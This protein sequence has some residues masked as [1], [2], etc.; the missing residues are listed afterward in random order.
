LQGA[1]LAGAMFFWSMGVSGDVEVRWG[2]S[3]ENDL[4][5]G[6]DR[7]D[8]PGIIRNTSALGGD[9]KVS[10]VPDR[11]RFV[12]DLK[13]VW[14]GFS[15]D[16]TFEGL[17]NYTVSSPLYLESNAAYVELRSLLP[18]LDVRFG[19]QIINWGAADMFN[20]TNNLNALNLEDP[21]MFGKRI[22]NQMIRIDYS[23]DDN[24]V[25]TAAW[26]PAFQPALLPPSSLLAIGDP[27]SEFPFVDP[28]VR[29]EAE[30]L[31]DFWL[32]SPDDWLISQPDVQAQMPGFALKNS[33]VGVRLGWTMGLFDASLS[34]YLG[35]DTM[36]VPVSSHS[37]IDT[38]NVSE[39][40]SPSGLP[41]RTI[42]TQVKLVYPRK[43]VL[44][45]DIT[46]QVPFLDDMGIWFE[47]A[48]VFPEAVRMNFDIT[49]IVP[50]AKILKGETLTSRPYFKCTTGV[51]YSI[52]QHF[53][54]LAQ[55]MRGFVDE[56]GA[57]RQNNYWMAGLDSKWIQEKLLLRLFVL[58]ELPHEDDDL[59]L[60]DERKD[61]TYV[62]SRAMGAT[63]D[64]TIASYAIFPQVTVKPWDGV[65][66]SAG[67][68][69]PLGHRESKFAQA[70]AGP[71][72]VFLRARASF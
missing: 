27:M 55:F 29:L 71:S 57:E 45:F 39:E 48:F 16:T 19:R 3:V 46:G 67:G 58:G 23:L 62:K 34:Y 50:G 22:A 36:P 7:V 2:A 14:T 10:M 37:K 24:F 20:P 60:M 26:V 32:S 13:I 30:R 33:Q 17:T 49:N 11:V 56:M 59:T 66:V 52:N 12:G 63:G 65:E 68:Y 1:L 9:I 6:V 53:F 47:G 69:F 25:L 18:R 54:I 70:A 28:T 41:K 72:L 4:R 61:G 40:R 15:K 44:G 5:A 42:L 64:G 51:D 35:L 8:E 38:V 31:R 21:I 43:Q